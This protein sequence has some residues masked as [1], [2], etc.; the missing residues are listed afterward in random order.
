MQGVPATTPGAQ[1]LRAA[2]QRMHGMVTSVT[3]SN[4]ISA[5]SKKISSIIGVID[6]ISFQANVLALK[7][8]VKAA[9]AGE[10]GRGFAVWL[11]RCERSRSAPWARPKTFGR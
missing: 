10:Q 11:L 3:S 6:G 8:A 4:E 5:S 1:A 7:A 9:R 2:F